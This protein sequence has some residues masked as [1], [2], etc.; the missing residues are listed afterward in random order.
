MT[1]EVDDAQGVRLMDL[2]ASVREVLAIYAVWSALGYKA[3]SYTSAAKECG[4]GRPLLFAVLKV[5]GEQ[6]AVNAG[7]APP[8][9]ERQMSRAGF[10][11]ND[12]PQAEREVLTR[13]SA[14]WQEPYRTNFLTVFTAATRDSGVPVIGP[15]GLAIPVGREARDARDEI[16]RRYRRRA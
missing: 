6:I 10:L 13:A 11:W 1:M 3:E 5:N 7:P 12:A 8:D 16:T 14:V 9:V 4:T 15:L 2:P